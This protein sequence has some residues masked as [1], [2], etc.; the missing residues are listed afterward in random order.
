L[1]TIPV[2][3]ESAAFLNSRECAKV[4]RAMGD[5][6]RLRILRRLVAGEKNVSELV[7]ELG[8]DQPSVSHHLAILRRA[9]LVLE[10]RRGKHVFYGQHPAVAQHLSAEEDKIDLGCC[11]VEL[12]RE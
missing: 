8:A 1:K 11:A 6:T 12:R 5:P 7:E 2:R 4:L 10:R 3:D 9:G